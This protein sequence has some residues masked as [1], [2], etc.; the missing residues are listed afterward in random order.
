[1][2]FSVE[3]GLVDRRIGRRPAA[4]GGAHT[5]LRRWTYAAPVEDLWDACTNPGRID[6]WFLPVTGDLRV[7]GRYQLEGHAGGDSVA[8]KPPR[9]LRMTWLLGDRPADEVEDRLGSDGDSR[10]IFEIE[11]TMGLPTQCFLVGLCLQAQ[12]AQGFVRRWAR[13]GQHHPTGVSPRGR[14]VP[15]T[16]CFL[17]G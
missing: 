10:T 13:R 3:I 7:G 14:E 15:G 16:G 4:S 12:D 1:M 2:D 6:R 11:H 5:V 17:R 9:L 8:C